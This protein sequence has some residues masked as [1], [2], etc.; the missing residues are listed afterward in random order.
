MQNNL[1][2][3]KIKRPYQKKLVPLLYEKIFQN[4]SMDGFDSLIRSVA[5]QLYANVIKC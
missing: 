1:F 5:G 2:M 4:R 3:R